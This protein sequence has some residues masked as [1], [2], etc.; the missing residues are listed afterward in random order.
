M[1][2]ISYGPTPNFLIRIT[3]K[4]VEKQYDKLRLLFLIAIC[5]IHQYPPPHLFNHQ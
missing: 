3:I 5:H 2:N 4:L 1:T